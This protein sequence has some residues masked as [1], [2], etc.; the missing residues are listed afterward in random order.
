MLKTFYQILINN[1]VATI[2]NFTV[3]FGLVFF[4]Y[5]QTRS[6]VVMSI[7]SAIYLTVVAF[8]GFWLGSF[9]DHYRK[10]RIMLVSSAISL[11]AYLFAFVLYIVAPQNAFT[12]ISSFYLWAL[13]LLNLFGVLAGNLRNIALP[14]LVTLLV[15][16]E[17]R[18]KANGLVGTVNGVSFL[19]VSMISGF[20]VGWGGLY[21]IGIMGIGLSLV[22][23]LHLAC[24]NIAEPHIVHLQHQPRKVDLKGTLTVIN[25][26][27][28]LLAL[29]FFTMF[30]NFLGGI[31]M[32]LMDAY[33]LSLISVEAWGVLWGILSLGFIVGGLI[34]AKWGLGK[35]PLRAMFR[36]NMLIWF[37]CCII[38]IQPSILLLAVG[39][40]IY[41]CVVPYIEASEQTI[42]QKV[43]PHDRQG[44]VFGFSQSVEQAAS[45]LMALII[46]PITQYLF[47]PFMTDGAGAR[48]IG[49]WFGTGPARGIALVF[50]VAGL[51]GLMTTFIC[52]RSKYYRI[53]SDYYATS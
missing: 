36:A 49:S 46:G 25:K 12:T 30:N 17:N 42:V 39:T 52:Y 43:V 44:R 24:F 45:P 48:L 33:G 10:Q 21:Y 6:V 18:D 8:S 32:S 47:I 9:V 28:G 11:T 13:I 5:L 26:V 51:I 7:M 40:F 53:L 41:L 2:T 27:P 22:T 14:T 35:S 23:L 4:V 3:W 50:V 19:I 37:L 1:V 16:A 38:T 29:I 20:L 31:F 15:P 34:I